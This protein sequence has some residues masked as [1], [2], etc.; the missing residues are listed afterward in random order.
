MAAAATGSQFG[1][2]WPEFLGTAA[3]VLDFDKT[4]TQRHTNGSVLVGRQ[5]APD[6]LEKNFADLAFF[7]EIIPVIVAAGAKVCIATYA[8]HAEDVSKNKTTRTTA[9]CM[10]V[11]LIFM[12]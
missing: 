10:P 5:L 3:I 12:C 2:E 11:A 6:V 9:N 1:A 7:R 8:D 4:I